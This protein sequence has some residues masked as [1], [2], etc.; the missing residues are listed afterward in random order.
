MGRYTSDALRFGSSHSGLARGMSL[1]PIPRLIQ[2]AIGS[3]QI[4][5]TMAAGLDRIA[6]EGKFEG[7]SYAHA[8]SA[9]FG[10]QLATHFL[11]SQYA[12][13]QNKTTPSDMP[14]AYYRSRKVG[15]AWAGGGDCDTKAST[16]A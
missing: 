16:R 4:P 8:A 1:G 3:E 6:S 12:G 9:P 11:A 2:P 13:V 7:R 14:L 10:P 15:Y 5:I